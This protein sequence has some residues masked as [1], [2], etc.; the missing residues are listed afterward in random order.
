MEINNETQFEE[1]A[2]RIEEIQEIEKERGS[3]DYLSEE[4][5]ELMSAVV[6]YSRKI[7]PRNS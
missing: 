5:Q 3:N 2:A 4:L 1:V 6:E 7:A